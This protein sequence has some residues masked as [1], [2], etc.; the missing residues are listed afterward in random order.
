MVKLYSVSFYNVKAHHITETVDPPVINVA[1]PRKNLLQGSIRQAGDALFAAVNKH[2]H[3][4]DGPSLQ[5]KGENYDRFTMPFTFRASCLC[6]ALCMVEWTA[7]VLRL[8]DELPGQVLSR[9][10]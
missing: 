5:G 4:S 7:L 2:R 10:H 6:L 1:F 9:R 8:P 3:L